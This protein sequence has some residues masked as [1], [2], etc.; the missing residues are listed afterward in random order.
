M[1]LGFFTPVVRIE[2]FDGKL[3]IYGI[4]ETFHSRD[5]Q[6]SIS[7]TLF[8]FLDLDAADSGKTVR[9]RIRVIDSDGDCVHS[10]P[11]DILVP[12]PVINA[13]DNKLATKVPLL[14][15][16]TD[17]PFTKWGVYRIDAFA[18]GQALG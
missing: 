14:F 4:T 17:V 7:F 15:K 8:V 13:F 2:T 6:D 10:N 1:K 18:D 3:N 16:Y 12:L 9:L 5:L 11:D